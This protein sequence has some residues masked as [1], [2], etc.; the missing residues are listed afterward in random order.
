MKPLQRKSLVLLL[1][2]LPAVAF[3][4]ANSLE[5]EREPAVVE[6]NSLGPTGKER[7]P[8]AEPVIPQA[9]VAI[10]RRVIAGGGGTSAGGSIRIEGTVGEVSVSG[11]MSGGSLT[12]NGGFWNTLD[13][14]PAQ[15][16]IQFLSTTTF[17]GEG[18]LNVVITVT[19][20]GDTRVAATVDYS[21]HDT[22]NFTVGCADVVNNMGGAF[23]RCDFAV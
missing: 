3:A 13:A 20:S 18:S 9:I 1:S 23:G 11:T 12:L 17:V 7:T 19:R 16:T 2:V 15:S 21:T 6:T 5:P 8:K 22:D 4:F 14:A 10:D